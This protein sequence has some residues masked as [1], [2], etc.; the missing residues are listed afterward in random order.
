MMWPTAH[1]SQHHHVQDFTVTA[2]CHKQD[3]VAAER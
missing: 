1:C 2:A 3:W